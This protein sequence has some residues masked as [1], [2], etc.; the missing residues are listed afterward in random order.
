MDIKDYLM[1]V[2][3]DNID[4]ASIKTLNIKANDEKK[5]ILL[6]RENQDMHQFIIKETRGAYGLIETTNGWV[7][8]PLKPGVYDIRK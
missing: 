6:I 8:I 1:I 7:K 4:N 2:K 5:I 3:E